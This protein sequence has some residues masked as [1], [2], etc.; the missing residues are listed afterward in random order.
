MAKN[1]KIKFLS[2]VT[3]VEPLPTLKY[4]HV[5][6]SHNGPGACLLLGEASS[7]V[8]GERPTLACCL[9]PPGWPAAPMLPLLWDGLCPL[10]S[11]PSL[12]PR[13]ILMGQEA[14]GF[15][16]PAFSLAVSPPSDL[17][18]PNNLN[19]ISVRPR[20]LPVQ[21]PHFH[22]AFSYTL[23]LTALSAPRIPMCLA[24][25]NHK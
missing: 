24:V 14:E 17:S 13:F 7:R 18:F 12:F 3:E 6:G 15:V 9:W 2:Q 21:I 20:C 19:R 5:K 11:S 22:G 1:C 10:L 23:P 8:S 25:V 4:M 16:L